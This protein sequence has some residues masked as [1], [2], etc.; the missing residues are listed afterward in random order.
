M[1]KSCDVSLVTLFGDVIAMT[2]LKYV[3]TDFLK[4]DF[5][6]ISVKYYILGKSRNIRPPKS[7]VKRRWGR[8]HIFENLL[9]FLTRGNF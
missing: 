8:R 7:K 4:F 3:I 1:E 5:V 6:I 2:S 9:Q